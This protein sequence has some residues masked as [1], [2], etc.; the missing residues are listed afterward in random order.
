MKRPL[1][2]CAALSVTAILAFPQ[3]SPDRFLGFKLGSDRNLAGYSQIKAY[4]QQ[5]S[6]ESPRVRTVTLGKTTKGNDLFL[7]VISSADNLKELEKY[8]AI[9]RQLAQ[10]EVEP[11]AAEQL[12]AGGKAIVVVT[13]NLHSTEIASSQMAMEL[14]FL[15]A[16]AKSQEIRDILDNVILVLFPSV[17]PDGQIMEVE[18]YDKTKNTEYEGTGAPYLY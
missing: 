7:A 6:L 3:Q 13:C 9:T 11:E 16:S 8:T 12:A 10:A 18:W 14:G 1:F 15:L 17:N 2:F 5:L 4:F